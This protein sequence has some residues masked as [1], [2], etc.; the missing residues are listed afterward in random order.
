MGASGR[1][2][3]QIDFERLKDALVDSADRLVP[4]WLSGGR[5]EGH[6]W[7]CGNLQGGKGRSLSVNLTTGAWADFA[8]EGLRGKD[9]ISLYAAIHGLDQ[10]DAAIDL[11]RQLRVGITEDDG[12]EIAKAERP[13]P[14]PPKAKKAPAWVPVVP[15][16]DDAPEPP[17]AHEFR[18]IPDAQW[19]YTDREGRLLG[20]VRRYRTSDGGKDIIPLVWAHS[21]ARG[22]HEWRPMHWTVPRPLYGLNRLRDDLPILIVE[23]EKCADAGHEALGATFCVLSWPG[24]GK[25][26]SKADWQPL[27]GRAVL[28][29]PDCD[30]KLYPDTHEKA[31]EMRP[32]NE[33]PGVQ[34]AE[35]VAEQLIALGGRVRIVKI[36][37]PGA[38]PDGWDIADAVADGWNADQL[39]AFLKQQRPAACDKSEPPPTEARAGK[40]T[41]RR[42]LLMSNSGAPRDCRENV[43]VILRDHP[44]W[45]GVL[46]WDEFAQRV[47]ARRPAPTGQPPD[48]VWTDQDDIELGLWLSRKERLLVRS[49]DTIAQAIGYVARLNRFHPVREYLEGLEWDGKHR[50]SRW[51]CDY[52]GAAETT[53]HRL[54]GTFFLINLVRRIMQPG[55]VMRS[56]MVLEGGQNLGKSRALFTLAS[57]WYSD[58]MFRVGDK[59]AYLM[60]QGVWLYEI[61]ELE[62]FTRSEATAVKAFVSTT[63]D[64]FR[65]PYARQTESHPRQGGFAGSTNASE[66][67]KDFSGNTRFWP[68]AVGTA[69]DLPGLA[70]ARDQLWA[71]AMVMVRAGARSYP[72]REEEDKYFREQQDQR[73]VE[74]PWV[75]KIAD[76]LEKNALTK[77]SVRAV[78]EHA[79]GVD[80]ARASPNGA[81]SQRVGQI[82]QQLGWRK[83]RESEPPR[84]WYWAAPETSQTATPEDA[85]DL[86]F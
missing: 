84:R 43:I 78:L 31:G 67:L 81:E 33:Q 63:E 72:T 44:E 16:P 17:A 64:K 59:D 35:A 60:I 75:E 65:A 9:L 53:Y 5:R 29:W 13:E 66:Y 61:S 6:E 21:Q 52:L 34:A 70:A 1:R 41:W 69:I 2:G 62:S 20:V 4:D 39:K 7:K 51:V 86:P 15:V 83:L 71:E 36:P 68:L 37:P 42:Q 58:T 55:C 25:A 24:G 80:L 10:I 30:A 48:H 40:P 32:E 3:P 28:I 26:V 23:G 12:R 76:Y 19:R 79:L 73:Q 11:A 38:K 18:G 74:H 22:R 8:D 77:I 54:V 46:G 49:T 50:V 47:V 45:D 82:M 85:S 14:P 27:A 56:V 57:P